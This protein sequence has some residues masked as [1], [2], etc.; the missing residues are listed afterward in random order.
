MK[1][2]LGFDGQNKTATPVIPFQMTPFCVLQPPRYNFGR[3]R[4]CLWLVQIYDGRGQG[5]G[6]L[7]ELAIFLF[8]IIF[9]YDG[10]SHIASS[11]RPAY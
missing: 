2:P 3:F 9:F 8:F 4:R 1:E 10:D 11:F 7:V 5:S 6:R